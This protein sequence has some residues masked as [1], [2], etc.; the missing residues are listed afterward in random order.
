MHMRARAARLV[1]A[2]I[3]VLGVIVA[4]LA[5]TAPAYAADAISISPLTRTAPSNSP[6]TYTLTVSCSTSGGCLNSTVSFPTTT[7]TGDGSTTDFAS[8]VTNSTCPPLTKPAGQAVFSFGNIG[9][10][11]QS[12]NFTVRPPNKTTLNGA[13][14]TIT[15]TFTN[16]A[17]SVTASSPAVLTVSAGHNVG[18]G[19]AVAPAN[20]VGGAPLTLTFSLGCGT[21]NS[22]GDLGLTALH[23]EDALPA[24]FTFG[25]LSTAPASL[26]GTLSAP[27]VGSSGGT[28]TYDGD[29]S[30]CLNP[31]NNR[32]VF[33]IQ[34]TAS[35]NGVPDAVG[36]KV[37]HSPSSTFTYV[38]G[39]STSAVPTPN[40]SPCATVIEKDWKTG[41][42]VT[43]KTMANRG[44]YRALDNTA[45]SL[46]TFP[47]D[48][49][50][51]ATTS[52]D[53]TVSS[54]PAVPNAGL[55][56]DIKD[57]LP[58][59]DNVSGA[60]YVSNSP[61]VVCANPAYIPKVVSVTGFTPA[62]GAAINVLLADGTTQAVPYVAGT[63][64]TL[65]TSPAV[66]EIDIPPFVEEGANNFSTIIFHVTGYASPA[67]VPGH[68]LTNSTTV[69]GY[70]A[71]TST[72]VKSVQG[73]SA[74]IL[75]A[76]PLANGSGAL[77]VASFDT[78]YSG[79]CVE[80]VRPSGS[81]LE[82]TSAPSQAIYLDYLGPEDVGAIT[83]PAL[84]FTLTGANG[85]TYSVQGI[86]PSKQVADYNGTGRTLIEWTIP[87]GLATVPGLYTVGMLGF[88]VDLGA[89][90]AGTFQN[91]MTIGYGTAIPG[92]GAAGANQTPPLAPP[93]DEELDTNGSP[94]DG[95]YCGASAPLS[96]D[97]FNAG[98]DVDKQV[99]G[100]LDASPIGGGGIGHVSVDG[101]A[102]TYTVSFTNKGESTLAD[103]VMYDLLPRIGDTLASSTAPRNSQFAVSL[104]G[105]GDLPA[106]LSVAYSQAVNP[107]R[108]EVLTPNPGCVDDWSS[109]PPSPLSTVTALRF[110]YDGNV[111]VDTGFTA[112]YTVSTPPSAAGTVAWNSIGTNVIAGSALLGKAESSLTGLQAQSAQRSRW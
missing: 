109:T 23:I 38:D 28:I 22:V 60:K 69:T 101:G 50:G 31:A 65:P 107:C 104:T 75:V 21:T 89:G 68:I 81:L 43:P 8:W 98:F 56:Y 40:A 7:L 35:T 25:S 95:N 84:N 29:G 97:A 83:V 14:A 106:N 51:G 59:I 41:K 1:V 57:P 11:T 92:C 72:Q 19:A 30:D 42:S 6:V 37:C 12:C 105:V 99:Q 9:T 55:S 24:N 46:Y 77:T 26:Q 33:T 111:R 86:T 13:K 102:A 53:I 108:P 67:A 34:G 17:G 88:D 110:T 103:P 76:D 96:L 39:F 82:I 47:G 80:R 48:W 70:L 100:N 74:S 32:I 49:D 66:S 54:D 10:G 4:G 112:T 20:V 91:A 73:Q 16:D 52:Y 36:T 87:A 85:K 44:Q 2:G 5:G 15:P 58:C 27:A 62:A 78:D 93:G 79:A 61:G 18:M 64:W 90:C 63:G 71:G 3:A 94:I 45:P